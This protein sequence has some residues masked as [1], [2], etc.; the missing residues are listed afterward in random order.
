M[1]KI[2]NTYDKLTHKECTA[3]HAIWK[4]VC[5]YQKCCGNAIS[6]CSEKLYENPTL[7]L[8][9]QYELEMTPLQIPS[10]LKFYTVLSAIQFCNTSV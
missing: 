5:L 10:I 2:C 9:M 7:L 4:P 3:F 1:T 8:L 6:N